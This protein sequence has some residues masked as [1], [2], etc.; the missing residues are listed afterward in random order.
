MV[1]GRCQSYNAPHAKFCAECG[2]PLSR[3]CKSDPELRQ[4]TVLFCDLV[5]STELAQRQDAEDLRDLILTYQGCCSGIVERFGGYVAQFLG[6]GVLAYFGYP[7]AY[8]HDAQRAVEAGLCI[9]DEIRALRMSGESL[10]IRIGIHTGTVVIGAGGCGDQNI[11]IAVG[12][13]PNV[14]ARLQSEAE[15]QTILIS[16]VTARLVR[17]YFQLEK[18]S[19]RRLKGFARECGIYR[20]QAL[21]T[22]GS[23][24]DPVIPLG[25]SPLIGRTQELEIA[26]K[27]WQKTQRRGRQVLQI[28]GEP[29]IGK[30]RFIAVL[31]DE[32]RNSG[33]RVVESRCSPYYQ[34]SAL[35]PFI[36]LLQR[37]LGFI[38]LDSKEAKYKSLKK[39]LQAFGHRL[40]EALPIL[41]ALLN[42]SESGALS[43]MA[44]QKERELTLDALSRLINVRATGRPTIFILEDLQWAD[45]STLQLVE[46][47]VEV[48]D[49]S[50]ILTVL[51]YRPEL[52]LPWLQ[53]SKYLRLDLGRLTTEQSARLIALTIG[54]DLPS[55]VVGYV[56]ARAEG[57][58]L[59]VEEITKVVL[60]SGA[61]TE[62]DGRYELTG[63]IPRALI[64]NT[65][66]DWLTARFDRLGDALPVAQLGAAI[67]REFGYKLLN[68]VSR[69]LKTDVGEALLKLEDAQLVFRLSDSPEPFFMFKHALIRD[70][71]YNSLL[72]H[73]RHRAHERIAQALEEDFPEIVEMQPELVAHH[74]QGAGLNRKAITYW[75][76]AGQRAVEHSA[77]NEAIGHFRQALELLKALPGDRERVQMEL[78]LQTALAA[79]LVMIKGYAAH[80]VQSVYFRARELCQQVGGT[81]QLFTALR[82][83]CVFYLVRGEYR[84]AYDLASQLLSIAEA[85]R[86]APLVME[87]HMTLGISLFYMGHIRQAR[88]HLAE[89]LALYDPEEHR[90][91]AFR[92]GQDP[93]I[94]SR[95]FD[96]W[97]LALLGFTDQARTAIAATVRLA[98]SQCCP[99][100]LAY[101][102][103]FES[104][105]HQLCRDAA[106]TQKAAEAE[107]SVS[108]EQ[109]FPLFAG[110]GTALKGWA[111]VE[112]GEEREGIS[113]LRSG[114]DAWRST[115][116][117]LARSYWLVLLA[118]TYGRMREPKMGLRTIAE[119]LTAMQRNEER[120]YEAELYRVKGEL[121]LQYGDR[122]CEA[123]ASF[124]HAID[125]SRAQ[126]T[127][128]LEL[129]AVTSLCLL[130]TKTGR[131]AEARQLLR[132]TRHRLSEGFDTADFRDA[133]R[134]PTGLD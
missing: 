3:A 117:E 26:R 63:S 40:T 127:T 7:K 70:T 42:I 22:E 5:G 44:P 78:L 75:Q 120:F 108:H 48:H 30:S 45:P 95:G 19:P 87:A 9:L 15:P 89:A 114:I 25:L 101:A 73:Q 18:L 129:K 47:L 76:K 65:V 104:L 128:T 103:H 107:I 21:R 132:D 28:V 4:L 11:Y 105:I 56:L 118:D 35:H 41:A 10:A 102:L 49:R 90:T 66:L 109:G 133:A 29:G 111:L 16:E 77:N 6:D 69:H 2:I 96:A 62:V 97:A 83:L 131:G 39:W 100:S 34:Q 61:L 37:E 86:S 91:H 110:G 125:T 134:L 99:F 119:A 32:V 122:Q 116:A 52:K 14:A 17:N 60:E 20:V 24:L 113:L 55:Y 36:E 46:K 123:E 23:F 115:G 58:P 13:T 88:T 31:R 67:G 38:R 68:A 54:T 85:E 33:A 71:A 50:P 130:W 92:Y 27:R 93:G 79:P 80:E 51:S 112:R 43:N 98:E 126:E 59:F 74:Y 121:L 81:R 84:T 8:E 53:R 57:V 94:A 12:E 106:A 82:G 64:P 1:C 72:K 124:R